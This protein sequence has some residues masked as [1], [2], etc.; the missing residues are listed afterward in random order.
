M[1]RYTWQGLRDAQGN[2]TINRKFPDM[3]TLADYVHSKGLK[4][5]IYSSPGPKA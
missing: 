4:I 1:R 5:G 3:K 2:I